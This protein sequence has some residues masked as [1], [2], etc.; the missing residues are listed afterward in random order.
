MYNMAWQ[1]SFILSLLLLLA[2]C[3]LVVVPMAK[4]SRQYFREVGYIRK[5]IAD[6]SLENSEA[7]CCSINHQ[8]P[9]F[10]T[11]VPCDRGIIRRCVLKWF[12]S[13][14]GFHDRVRGD[15]PLKGQQAIPSFCSG[16]CRSC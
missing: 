10:G 6:F 7:Y 1:N 11:P 3:G 9:V 4:M 14:E 12:G 5:Q 8:D 16:N 15:V 2:Y 13:I